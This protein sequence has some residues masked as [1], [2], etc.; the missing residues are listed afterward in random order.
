MQMIGV[1]T[2]DT[3]PTCGATG[4]NIVDGMCL[5]CMMDNAVLRMEAMGASPENIAEVRERLRRARAGEKLPPWEE[6][7]SK[8]E[9][10]P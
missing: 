7:V 4:D 1:L 6:K 3:C 10:E 8:P 5:L 9:G 2:G